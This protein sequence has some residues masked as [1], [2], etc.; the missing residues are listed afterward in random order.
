MNNTFKAVKNTLQHNFVNIPGWHTPRKIVVIESDDWG[1]IRMPSTEVY[2]KFLSA[3]YDLAGSNYNKLDTL[4]SNEDLLSLFDV[5]TSFTDFKG[6]HPAL[7][8]NF[9]VCNPDFR[10]IREA[11]FIDYYY[12]P[13][14]ETL[15]RYPGRDQVQALWR[16][17]ISEKIFYPQF[18]SREHVN[19]VRWME[20][21]RK[22]TPNM[23]FTFENETTFSGDG[24]YNFMEVLDYNT[25]AD[26]D[27]MRES[28]ADGLD[29]FESIFGYRSSSFIPPCYTWS[30]ALEEALH[31]GGVRYMQ[32]LLIQQVPTGKFGHYKRKYHFLGDRNKF[33]QYYLVRNCFFE[34]SLSSQSDEVDRCLARI[35]IAF[36]WHKPAVISSH[37]I[38]YIGALDGSNRDRSL[39]MLKRLLN[40]II[41]KW[42]DVEFLTSDKLGDL[43]AGTS[44]ETRV[45]G[46][47]IHTE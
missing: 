24:D 11:D 27:L 38:N 16:R 26:L 12:E 40:A 47:N 9:V 18:H 30:S 45:S 3:G 8:A 44:P 37:R 13:V 15:K 5:L 6:N 39:A 36:R 34:P 43:I 46:H 22:R 10:R 4:E 29:I 17:G 20:A 31:I 19:I 35:A 32:G 1:S 23:M 33:G 25:T 21:L 7:T 28:L 42:P 41:R 14:T 2:S